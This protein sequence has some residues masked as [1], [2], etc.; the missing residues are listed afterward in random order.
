MSSSRAGSDL[1]VRPVE[2]DGRDNTTFRLG[3]HLSVRLPSDEVYV[4]QI[5]KEHRWLPVLADRLAVPIPTPVAIGQPGCGYPRRWSVYRWLTGRPAA[6]A[7]VHDLDRF[8]EDLAEFLT[9]L[10]RVPTGGDPAPGAHNYLRGAP[11]GVYDDEARTAIA[12]LGGRID[13]AGAIDVS[14]TAVDRR[15][16]RPDVW[17]HGDVTPSNLLVRDDRLCGV[18]DF[19]CCAVGDPACDLTVAWTTFEGTSRQR[20]MQAIDAD[21]SMW[22][23]APGWA[24]WKAVKMLPESVPTTTR[25]TTAADSV[26]DGQPEASS[27]R[28]STTTR[29]VNSEGRSDSDRPASRSLFLCRSVCSRPT[30]RRHLTDRPAPEPLSRGV[31]GDPQRSKRWCVGAILPGVILQLRRGTKLT[32]H[33]RNELQAIADQLKACRAPG[34]NRSAVEAYLAGLRHPRYGS[35]PF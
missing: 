10:W 29:P 11:I 21:D 19:G 6:L 13:T 17:E 31:P 2:L 22:A 27:T 32:P 30:P 25:A 33:V 18:I 20:F 26:G 9:A 14:N 12:R 16:N 28:S 5:D 24:L 35:R 7:G 8:A 23:R 4:A 1:P 15:W 3:D 34:P